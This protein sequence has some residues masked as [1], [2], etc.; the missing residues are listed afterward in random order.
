ML[1][2][3]E[4]QPGDLLFYK[5]TDF[6]GWLIAVKTWAML[7]HVE[8]Y[9]GHGQVIAARPSGVDLYPERFD[10]SLRYVRRPVLSPGKRFDVQGANAAVRHML[11]KPYQY[12]GLFRFYAPWHDKHKA[13][14]ICSSVATVWLRGGGCE[15]F[16]PTVTADDVSPSM[17][18]QT[19]DLTT[20][21]ESMDG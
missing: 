7:S 1:V 16:N 15:P 13:T 9:V 21:W 17:L 8:C 20:V 18:N 4:L 10:T 5:P 2:P 19:N 12:S 14:R 6:I 11:G 3:E